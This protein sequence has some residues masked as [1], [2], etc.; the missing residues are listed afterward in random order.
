MVIEIIRSKVIRKMFS[1]PWNLWNTFLSESS[2][3]IFYQLTS[4]AVEMKTVSRCWVFSD[5]KVYVEG[6]W[7]AKNK[8]VRSDGRWHELPWS[9]WLEGREERGEEGL[10]SW[11]GYR[12]TLQRR[13][14]SL[15]NSRGRQSSA[16]RLCAERGYL[17]TEQKFQKSQKGLGGSERRKA[18]FLLLSS[19]S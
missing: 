1:S 8:M 12:R 2:G 13:A 9:R 18:V 15:Q 7:A 5:K 19:P 6:Q 14:A 17:T 4:T 10:Q 3:G 16:K 11:E